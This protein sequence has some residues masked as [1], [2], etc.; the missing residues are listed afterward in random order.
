MPGH[1]TR[2]AQGRHS[3]TRRLSFNWVLSN[4]IWACVQGT[5]VAVKLLL[6]DDEIT[7]DRIMREVHVLS[8][9]RHPNLIL[10][11]GFC[12]E[13]CC[14]GCS[15]LGLAAPALKSAFCFLPCLCQ[16]SLDAEPDHAAQQ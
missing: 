7:M 1:D 14:E 13:V 6:Q 2:P 4:N 16:H 5:V 10:F 3:S 15:A 8:K 12:L 9:L 11:I